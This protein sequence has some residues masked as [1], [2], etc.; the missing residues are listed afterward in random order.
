[1]S[2]WLRSAMLLLAVSVASG[3]AQTAGMVELT[4]EQQRAFLSDHPAAFSPENGAWVLQ[5]C[6]RVHVDVV[7]EETL[8]EAITLAWQNAAI[9]PAS[10]RPTPAR[11]ATPRRSGSGA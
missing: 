8:G 5:G 1:M 9:T 7:D 11:A 10:R 6:T 4:P 3:S 2:R